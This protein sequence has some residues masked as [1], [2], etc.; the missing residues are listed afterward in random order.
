[1]KKMSMVFALI[2]IILAGCSNNEPNGKGVTYSGE[3]KNWRA[4]IV[5]KISKDSNNTNYTL[6][7]E[8]KGDLDD[9]KDVHQIHYNFQYGQI[10][11]NRFETR[12]DGLPTNKSV[13]YKD[14]GTVSNESIN[15]HTKISLKIDWN[16]K[17]ED[18]ELN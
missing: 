10:E 6:S 16:D 9:L 4:V 5:D 7:I 12:P 1:M 14:T 13:L 8:Y 3:S 18:F 17:T 11:V 2:M 15:K